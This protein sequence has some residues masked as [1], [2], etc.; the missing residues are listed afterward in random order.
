MTLL[1]ELSAVDINDIASWSRRIK[2]FMTGLLCFVLIVG[3][4][5]WLVKPK[6]QALA[7]VERQEQVLRDEF[8]EKKALAINVD[9]YKQQMVDAGETFGILLRQLPNESEVPD[10]LVDMTQKGLSEGLQFEQFK[11]GDTIPREFYAEKLVNIKAVG[12]YHQVGEFVSE[13][14][15]LP[16]I[17]TFANFKLS[18][19]DESS[20]LVT[21]EAVTKTYH[22]LEE[23]FVQ[24]EELR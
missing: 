4:Y 18:R 23:G 19:N 1:E 12:T 16:R 17:I 13:I 15:A 11:M 24:V 10:L 22:Y 20:P 21:F 14:A 5:Y 9:A 2:L 8:L 3:G 7:A 6:E